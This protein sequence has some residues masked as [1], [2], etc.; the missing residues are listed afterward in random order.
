MLI[1]IA[2][3]KAKTPNQEQIID[4]QEQLQADE[5]VDVDLYKAGEWIT[6]YELALSAAKETNKPILINFTGSDWCIWCKRLQK[7]V[8]AENEFIEYAKSNL[9]LLKLDFPRNI[10][11]TE[12]EKAQNDALAKQYGIQG[13]PTIVLLSSNGKE[14]TRTGYQEGGPKKYVA[15]LQSLLASN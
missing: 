10:K 7:E 12:K 8:F 11:Q 9:I 14:I 2:A 3:C 6:D 4:E 1:S 15:H 5:P 13:F